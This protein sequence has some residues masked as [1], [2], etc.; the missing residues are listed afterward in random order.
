MNQKTEKPEKTTIEKHLEIKTYVFGGIG[1]RVR[2]DYVHEK[3]SLLN[4]DD[5]AK[6]WVFAE[7]TLEYMAGWRNILWAME[8]AIG[9]AEAELQKHQT[10]V[11]RKKFQLMRQL[12]RAK[13]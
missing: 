9:K 11:E 13:F 12:E 8:H 7:R 3:I 1:V 5:K 4:N 2:I 10:A 6:Q